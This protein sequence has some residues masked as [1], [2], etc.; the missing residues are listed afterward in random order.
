M[1][2]D[3]RTK[4]QL[5]LPRYPNDEYASYTFTCEQYMED[6]LELAEEDISE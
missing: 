6:C 3:Y 5:N 4:Q 2:T 1:D